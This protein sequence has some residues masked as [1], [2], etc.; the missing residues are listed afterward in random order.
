VEGEKE[1]DIKGRVVKW[2]VV[3]KIHHMHVCKCH[4]IPYFV[5]LIYIKKNNL[6]K[7]R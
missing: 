2:V 3:I 5:Q 6:K 4:G 7:S 1:E